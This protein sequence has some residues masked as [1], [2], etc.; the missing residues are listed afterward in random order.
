MKRAKCTFRPHNK[1]F[2]RTSI[3]KNEKASLEKAGLLCRPS[4][5]NLEP[6]VPGGVTG[7]PG[8]FGQ[9]DELN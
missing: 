2:L 6:P 9:S 1:A 8:F 3:H 7:N 5:P 4:T